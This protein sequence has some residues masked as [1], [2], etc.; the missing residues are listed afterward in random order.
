MAWIGVELE[1]T[2]CEED[3]EGNMYPT[4]GA[5]EVM[6]MLVG[7]GHRL[8]VLTDKFAPA[9]ESRK[10]ELK[11]FLEQELISM[12]FPETMEVWAGSVRPSTDLDIGSKSVTFDN[13]WNLALAQLQVMMEDRG[14]VPEPMPDDGSLDVMEEEQG[15]PPE[16][17]E[18][19][20]LPQ[21]APSTPKKEEKPSKKPEKK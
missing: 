18:E 13:D 14:L 1:G 12:G 7:E 21:K 19:P 4:E 15:M 9:P 3:L 5:A 16:M 20:A 2:L 11:Q 6:H 17:G 10:R 8:T